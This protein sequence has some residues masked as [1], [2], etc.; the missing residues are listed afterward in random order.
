[1]TQNKSPGRPG[2]EFVQLLSSP[3]MRRLVVVV[4]FL[5]V[6]RR[7]LSIVPLFSRTALALLR[8]RLRRPS[9]LTRSRFAPGLW[10][11]RRRPILVL[12]W[13]RLLTSLWRTRRLFWLGP[14]S[15]RACV[16]RSR[17]FRAA[18]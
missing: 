17:S 11:W 3:K 15:R 9:F 5:V 1:M 2:L 14:R 6:A 7:I 4:L 13:R 8:R 18:R 16:L 12:S 10:T